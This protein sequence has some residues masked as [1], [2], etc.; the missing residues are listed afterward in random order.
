[1]SSRNDLL[2]TIFDKITPNYDTQQL[3]LD[4]MMSSNDN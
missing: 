3:L 4:K 1:M 2:T